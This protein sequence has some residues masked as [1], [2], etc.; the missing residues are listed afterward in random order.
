MCVYWCTLQ[1]PPE[2][3]RDC[4]MLEWWL[5]FLAYL[6]N[7]WMYFPL[8]VSRTPVKIR[9]YSDSLRKGEPSL[10]RLS[11]FPPKWAFYDMMLAFIEIIHLFI[12]SLHF[13]STKV[14]VTNSSPLTLNFPGFSP[15]S[16]KTWENSQLQ[17][18]G[19]GWSPAN[20]S[21]CRP[22]HKGPLESWGRGCCLT[23][24]GKT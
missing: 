5:V 1:K 14:T 17:A 11:W 12:Q 22:W 16:L 19:D 9:I 21:G 15:W 4:P 3:Q 8:P 24:S 23:N 7:E 6:L 10:Q 18:H 20:D 13:L 2:E